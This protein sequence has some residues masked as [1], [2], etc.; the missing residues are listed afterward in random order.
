MFSMSHLPISGKRLLEM[1]YVKP[2]PRLPAHLAKIYGTLA[3]SLIDAYQ[4][5]DDLVYLYATSPDCVELLN[6]T[7]PAFFAR[8]QHLLAIALISSISRLADSPTSG[9]R[10]NPQENLTLELLLSLDDSD[11]PKQRKLRAKL[12]KL[13]KR[14][15]KDSDPIRRYRHKRIAHADRAEYLRPRK[16]LA[17]GITIRRFGRVLNDIA[18]F[19]NE[20]DCFFTKKAPLSYGGQ[21]EFGDV[22]DLLALLRECRNTTKE[23]QTR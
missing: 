15:H 8:Y 19:L 16:K 5:F 1:S 2:D 13:W 10:K 21:R 4:L 6:E 7:A 20:F 22:Q 9:S 14:L 23:S 18:R 12:D 17:K 11:D 3:G